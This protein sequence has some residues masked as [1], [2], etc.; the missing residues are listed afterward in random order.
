MQPTPPNGSGSA[1]SSGRFDAGLLTTEL[2]V[3]VL[4]LLFLFYFPFVDRHYLYNFEP[5]TSVFNEFVKH[6]LAFFSSFNIR[7][8][9][10]PTTWPPYFDGPYLIYTFFERAVD[11]SLRFSALVLPTLD[12]RIHFVVR[13]IHYLCLVGAGYFIFLS[14][15]SITKHRLTS[16]WLTAVFVL[17][18][19]MHAI[20]LSRQDHLVMALLVFC[21]YCVIKILD[22]Q[23]RTKYLYL[24]SMGSA[25]LVNTKLS[26]VAF[27]SIPALVSVFLIREGG[28]E[29]KRLAKSSLLFLVVSF[30]LGFRYVIYYDVAFPNLVSQLR[31]ISGWGAFLPQQ[32]F[33]YYGWA[34]LDFY[35]TVFRVLYLL[36][37]FYLLAKGLWFKDRL[38]FFISIHAIVYLG[39]SLFGMQYER[40]GYHLIPFILLIL[41][42]VI[43]DAMSAATKVVRSTRPLE[44]VKVI[45]LLPILAQPTWNLTQRYISKYAELKL[46][47][48]SVFINRSLPRSW[49]VKHYEQG[50]RIA[51]P[52]WSFIM[53]L[54]NIENEG[55][56]REQ[57]MLNVVYQS[58]D[59][60][61]DQRPP[62]LDEIRRN[63]DVLIV[64]DWDESF[65][66]GVF[67]RYGLADRY[68]EWLNF[69]RDLPKQFNGIKFASPTVVHGVREVSLFSISEPPHDSNV[70]DNGENY[71]SPGTISKRDHSSPLRRDPVL[72]LFP[73]E[74]QADQSRLIRQF[75][76][77]LE[78]GAAALWYD[79]AIQV[80]RSS[81]DLDAL[82]ELFSANGPVQCLAAYR[83]LTDRLATAE[84]GDPFVPS[85]TTCDAELALAEV[86]VFKVFDD[87]LRQA[88]RPTLETARAAQQERQIELCRVA[89][90]EIRRAYFDAISGARDAPAAASRP[91]LAAVGVD[92]EPTPAR[93]RLAS[94]FPCSLE[95]AAAARWW[96]RWNR[97][98]ADREALEEL[99]RGAQQGAI[100]CLSAYQRLTQRLGAAEHRSAY[101]PATA[102]CDSELKIAEVYVSDVFD[103][104][105]RR[106]TVPTLDA[107][108]LA[109]RQG[110]ID[111]CR[112]GVGEI[113]RAYFEAIYGSN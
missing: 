102:T 9:P 69:F 41:S 54:P 40:G 105:L 39:L 16:L 24:L 90:G 89:V 101:V 26:S 97:T 30:V 53:V 88:T 79:R 103:D 52:P 85:T 57:Q 44:V 95:S 91:R 93:V 11:V 108:R 58:A 76:C 78:T 12:S 63:A 33:L 75:P 18:P 28:S 62:S 100:R 8:L 77:K 2:K 56:K 65:V 84:K 67:S 72:T 36:G 6:Y 68:Q 42:S 5:D 46:R 19:V 29:Y 51:G 82:R 113:R 49:I 106:K 110:Q 55:Y 22:S 23:E 112:R 17:T 47:D 60:A 73:N 25:L 109:Q 7:E 83:T 66:L 34:A 70:Q 43:S 20:D 64:S 71:W 86:Y 111:E 27:I 92:F 99:F 10:A 37:S 48:R 87:P 107:A 32:S 74:I 94:R 4:A 3:T 81:A 61:R 59:L 21:N 80:T 14:T 96:D 1:L 45:I 13:W 98:S 104:S 35:G 15:L 50:S 38:A 31:D